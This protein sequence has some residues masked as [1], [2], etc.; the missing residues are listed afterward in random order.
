VVTLITA[1]PEEA[2]ALSVTV[3]LPAFGVQVG[4][5]VVEAPAGDEVKAQVSETIPP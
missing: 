4:R 2:E 3:K 1:F 5:F